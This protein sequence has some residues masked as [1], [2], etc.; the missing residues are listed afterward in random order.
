MKQ[1]EL[2]WL[3]IPEIRALDKKLINFHQVAWQGKTSPIKIGVYFY[4]EKDYK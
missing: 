4:P 2:K 1:V 3:T